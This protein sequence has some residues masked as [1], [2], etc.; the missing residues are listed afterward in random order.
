[1]DCK[2]CGAELTDETTTVAAFW[3]EPEDLSENKIQCS[4][5]CD[6]CGAV[7]YAQIE[8]HDLILDED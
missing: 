7:M 4:V 5:E 3:L 2:N 8:Y 6:S 1:M